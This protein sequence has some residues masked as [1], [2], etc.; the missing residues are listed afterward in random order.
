MSDFS[1]M[2]RGH[3]P[4]RKIL[5]CCTDHHRP[6]IKNPRRGVLIH[7]DE[8]FQSQSL[9]SDHAI[10][11]GKT[12]PEEE[13]DAQ[14]S[15]AQINT[16]D[17]APGAPIQRPPKPPLNIQ[18]S[19]FHGKFHVFAW[20]NAR[21]ALISIPEENSEVP[22]VNINV[23]S[24]RPSVSYKPIFSNMEHY[25]KE[26]LGEIDHFLTHQVNIVERMMYQKCIPRT[27]QIIYKLLA[28]EST[29]LTGG[30]GKD[31][32]FQRIYE[33]KIDLVN[34]AETLFQFFLPSQFDGPT[35]QKYWGAIYY[36]LFVSQG[37]LDI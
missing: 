29:K 22:N 35:V 3:F 7:S 12:T 4:N 10:N 15:T 1:Y 31:L 20:L 5:P 26:D 36:L 9:E 34:A 11:T 25:I 24:R 30:A 17:N 8:S 23:D 28:D 2:L 27:R 21:R 14:A 37:F 33:T 32:S 16:S 13:R 6:S 19:D 18:Y